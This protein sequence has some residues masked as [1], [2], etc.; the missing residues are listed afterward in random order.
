MGQATRVWHLR[1][2]PRQ[3]TRCSMSQ[4]NHSNKSV[5]PLEQDTT[6]IAVIEM[7]QASWLVA[8]NRACGWN[9]DR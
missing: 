8:G 1:R 3:L 7:S 5:T 6:M 9:V 2:F 4:P